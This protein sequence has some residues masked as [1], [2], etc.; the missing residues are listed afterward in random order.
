MTFLGGNKNKLTSQV[1]KTCEV[2]LS[3]ISHLKSNVYL[4]RFQPV[5]AHTKIYL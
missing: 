1:S 2:N 4:V 3:N 5:K